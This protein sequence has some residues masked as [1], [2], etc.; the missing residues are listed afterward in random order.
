MESHQ[1]PLFDPEGDED[2]SGCRGGEQEMPDGHHRR[3]PKRE[4]EAEHDGMTH[5]AIEAGNPEANRC[6]RTPG[7]IEIDLSEAEQVEVV[8][9]KCGHE[10]D[11]PTGPEDGMDEPATNRIFD[12]PDDGRNRSPLPE[13]EAEGEAAYED[14]SASL[15]RGRDEPC[16]PPLERGPGHDAVRHGEEEEE[17]GIDEDRDR[18]Q[19]LRPRI[20]RLRDEE[21]ADESDRVQERSEEGEIAHHAVDQGDDSAHCRLNTP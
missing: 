4:D 20:N 11:G 10:H 1:V 7:S 8:N 17:Q 5:I 16:P 3:S 9:Q 21:I 19:A 12:V 2:V 18:E 14:I 6:V 13:E 15:D